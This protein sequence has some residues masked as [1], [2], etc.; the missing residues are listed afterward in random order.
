MTS[1]AE[2]PVEVVEPLVRDAESVVVDERREVPGGWVAITG[3]RVTAVG[4]AGTQ[5]GGRGDRLRPPDDRPRRAPPGARPG[6][7]RPT[8]VP[9]RILVDRAE[10]AL[11]ARADA[12]RT[13]GGIART[14]STAP[15]ASGG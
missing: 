14:R 4:S 7:G 9:A 15:A 8:I 12:L 6:S 1:A 11:P 3:G 5:A 13:H 2:A 10:P